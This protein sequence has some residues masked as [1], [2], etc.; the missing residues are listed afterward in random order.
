MIFCINYHVRGNVKEFKKVV[1]ASSKV[2]AWLSI[3]KDIQGEAT[4]IR[5]RQVK[6]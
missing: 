5:I 3:K 1:N 6:K 4:L 2:G